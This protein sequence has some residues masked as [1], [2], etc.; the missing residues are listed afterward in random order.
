MSEATLRNIIHAMDHNKDGIVHKV[1]L[2]SGYVPTD[3]CCL[4]QSLPAGLSHPVRAACRLL[5]A[6]LQACC[7]SVRAVCSAPCAD[8]AACSLCAA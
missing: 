3:R 8:R 5:Q 4:L 7:Y 6:C 2:C 1:R